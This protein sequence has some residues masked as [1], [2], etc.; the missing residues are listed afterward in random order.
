[1]IVNGVL[2][3]LVDIDHDPGDLIDLAGV[4]KTQLSTLRAAGQWWSTRY[5]RQREELARLAEALPLPQIELPYLFGPGI[6]SAESIELSDEL[7]RGV[8]H[9]D[10]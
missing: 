9:L 6:K 8:T 7:I 5:S 4:P 2:P 3:A 1:V 10:G